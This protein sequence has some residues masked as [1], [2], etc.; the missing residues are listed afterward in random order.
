M[1][2]SRSRIREAP[3]TLISPLRLGLPDT[4]QRHITNVT[5]SL[6]TSPGTVSHTA[7]AS[8]ESASLAL[9]RGLELE[10]SSSSDSISFLP[11]RQAAFETSG[12]HWTQNLQV[13]MQCRTILSRSA[14]LTTIKHQVFARWSYTIINMAPDRH[15]PGV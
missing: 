9:S 11:I 2:C 15:R 5:V 10:A 8:S 7:L 3:F 6:F 12:S 1:P 13:H 14:L 4:L